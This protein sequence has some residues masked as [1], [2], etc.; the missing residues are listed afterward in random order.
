MAGNNWSPHAEDGTS[1]EDPHHQ[2]QHRL[3]TTG[4]DGVKLRPSPFFSFNEFFL[5]LRFLSS[6]KREK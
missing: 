4:V 5:S 3:Y 1:F 6:T 2:L